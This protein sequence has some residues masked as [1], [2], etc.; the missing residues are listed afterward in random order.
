MRLM[1]FD[2]VAEHVPGKQL[3]VADALSR[4]PLEG[5]H[6]LQTDDQVRAFVNTVVASKPIKPPKMEEIRTE[7]QTDAELRQVTRFIRKGWLRRL[8]ESSTLHGFYAA[9]AHLSES[10]GLVLY[11]DRIVIPTALRSNVLDQL[12]KGHLGLTKCRERARLTVWWP[13]I[14]SHISKKVKS[15]N[16]CAEQ[17]PTQ[18]REP[19]VVTPLP[20]GPWQKIAADLCELEGKNYLIVVDYFSRDIEIAPLMTTTSRQVIAKLKHMFVR[21]GIPLEVISDNAT[22]FTSAEFQEFKH[23]YGFT[24]TTSS[25]HYPQSNG[26]AERAVQTAKNILKQ[27]DPCLALMSYRST[28]ITATGASPAQLMTGRPIRTTVPVLETSLGPQPVDWDRV[29]QKDAAAKDA[30]KYFYNCRH[31]ARPLPELHPGQSVRVKLDGDKE[32]KTPATVIRKSQEPRSY[33]VEMDNGT[34]TRRNRR[35]L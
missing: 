20:G 11:H 34:V 26:A 1:R 19:L 6:T 32:W 30:Y 3:A 29:Y 16:F 27:P 13:G 7:T 5:D 14:G 23:S 9:R 25:P 17:R 28:P 33:V 12:H 10:D 35:H 21:W 31:S 24:H 4:H 2:V 8:T 18:R 15:C 22:Q